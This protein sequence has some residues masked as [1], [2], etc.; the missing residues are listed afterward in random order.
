MWKMCLKKK[1]TR[2]SCPLEREAYIM[3]I[4]E[5]NSCLGK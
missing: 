5:L 1:K 3:E 2:H 4:Q